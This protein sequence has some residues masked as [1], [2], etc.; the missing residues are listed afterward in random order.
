MLNEQLEQVKKDLARRERDRR[1]DYPVPAPAGADPDPIQRQLREEI[2]NLESEL[3]ERHNERNAMQ[4]RLEKMEARAE[5]LS[6]EL[7]Q[8]A[9]SAAHADA[10]HEED[11]L[12]PQE[13]E[14]NHPIRLVEFPRNFLE[15]LGE[16]PHHIARGAMIILGRLAGGEAAAFNGAKRLK[17]AP[18]YMRQR[19]G[20]DFR[21]LFRLLPDRIQVIDLIPRQDLERRIKAL[22]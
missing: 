16:F 1:P 14:G 4:R 22:R 3:K 15:R 13:A 21:L 6:R 8:A 17:S 12:L 18:D 9:P 11:L 7:A 2:K 19:V 10:E 5:T 20:I